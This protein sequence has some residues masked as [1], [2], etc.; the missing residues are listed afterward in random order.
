MGISTGAGG[1]IVETF[2]KDSR[3]TESTLGSQSGAGDDEVIVPNAIGTNNEGDLESSPSY[4]GRLIIIR[5]ECKGVSGYRIENAGSSYVVSDVVTLS[6]G[7]KGNA[8]T[9]TVTSVDS[10]AV[11][12]LSITTAG[13]Y[14]VTPS[15]PV[16]TTG[17]TG[18]GL[19]L[20]IE[21]YRNDE[22]RYITADA[23]N[24]L[25]VHEDWIQNPASGEDWALFYII[26]DVETKTGCTFVSKSRLYTFSRILIIGVTPTPANAGLALLDGAALELD[27]D[28]LNITVNAEGVLQCGYLLDGVPTAG[29]YLFGTSTSTGDVVV[30]LAIDG[31]YK[32]YDVQ[33]RCA[34]SSQQGLHDYGNYTTS[35]LPV[36]QSFAINTK[37]F[38]SSYNCWLPDICRN[39]IIVGTGSSSEDIYV[40]ADEDVDADWNPGGIDRQDVT[41]IQ[42]YGMRHINSYNGDTYRVKRVTIIDC[43]RHVLIGQDEKWELVDPIGLVMSATVTP[44]T[45]LS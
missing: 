32:C 43:A 4:V 7:T 5:P 39:L 3:L 28:T 34:I 40:K 14:T 9:L 8:A 25:T 11:T 23:S 33:T 29:P 17:G 16:S 1:I 35:F 13:D 45:A 31:I 2:A 30:R 41:L 22:T 12:G 36:R 18:T 21:W 44:V 24:T 15:D 10:G 26:E 19:T 20:S 37:W 38:S 42:T 6:G 27:D